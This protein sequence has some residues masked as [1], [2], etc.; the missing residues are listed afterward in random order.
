MRII[1][2]GAS[3]A[4]VALGLNQ[5]AAAFTQAACDQL[6]KVQTDGSGREID[7]KMRVDAQGNCNQDPP[8]Q[9]T[10]GLR[11]IQAG[12]DVQPRHP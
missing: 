5:P 1:V 4:V 10:N 3:A 9:R 12:D 2:V 8:N 11:Q 6:K 7:A